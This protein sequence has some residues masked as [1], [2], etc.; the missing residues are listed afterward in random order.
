MGSYTN[1]RSIT[2]RGP[3]ALLGLIA[4]LVAGDASAQ[5]C[6][7]GTDFDPH[8]PHCYYQ[9]TVKNDFNQPLPCV[10]LRTT[11][12][13]YTTDANGV[14]KFFEPGLMNR[15]VFFKPHRDGFAL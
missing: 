2:A 13:V 7:S 3:G 14:V 15:W 12:S 5:T 9:I 8:V 6:Q 11:S 1:G 4:L 10:E